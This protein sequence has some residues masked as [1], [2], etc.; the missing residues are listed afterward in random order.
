MMKHILD[1]EVSFYKSFSDT[2]NPINGSLLQ[3]VTS[4]KLAKNTDAL[5]TRIRQTTDHETRKN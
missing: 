2:N 5:I 3:I 4:E 1:V